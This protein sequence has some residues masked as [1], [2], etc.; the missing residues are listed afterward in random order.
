L[1][2]TIRR[3]VDAGE[4][5]AKC[6]DFHRGDNAAEGVLDEYTWVSARSKEVAERDLQHKVVRDEDDDEDELCLH[7]KAGG[8]LE[9]VLLVAT[10]D[11]LGPAAIMIKR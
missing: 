5:I 11:I 7:E 1:A 6:E 3:I 10:L 8:R 4:I 9:R 2:L